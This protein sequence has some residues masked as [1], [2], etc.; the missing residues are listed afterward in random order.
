M[1]AA[2]RFFRKVLDA[3][4][5]TLP[6]VITVDKNAAYPLAFDVLQQR[7]HTSRQLSAQTV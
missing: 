2:E 6:R 4:H 5:T 7:R 3:S 1:H